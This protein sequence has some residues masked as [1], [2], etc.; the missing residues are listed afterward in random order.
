MLDRETNELLCQVGP[1]TPMGELLR[2][3]WMPIG[4]VAEVDEMEKRPVR[5][6][7]ENLLVFKDRQ[8]R[9]GLLAEECSHRGASLC[10]GKV[11]QDGIRCPYHGWK[12]DVNGNC[13]EQ[14]A[15]PPEASSK[16]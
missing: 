13:L 6:L 15:E 16:K 1:G 10:Y 4:P 9:Y 11:E 14:P 7:G 8:G 5:L 2:R 3:Y 12:Y